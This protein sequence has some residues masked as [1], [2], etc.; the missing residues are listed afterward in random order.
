MR[1][2]NLTPR[3]L[4]RRGSLTDKVFLRIFKYFKLYANRELLIPH[5][6]PSPQERGF[7]W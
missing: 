3:P 5:P 1:E 7:V 6:P 4:R 2:S